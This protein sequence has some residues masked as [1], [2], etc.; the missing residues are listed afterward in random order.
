MTAR[1]GGSKALHSTNTAPRL[2]ARTPERPLPQV[3]RRGVGRLQHLP[4]APDT[5]HRQALDVFERPAHLARQ[6]HPLQFKRIVLV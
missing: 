2:P 5:L 3:R 4:H 1:R 6:Q